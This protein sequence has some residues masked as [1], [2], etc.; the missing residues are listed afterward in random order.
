MMKTAIKIL[1][2]ILCTASMTTMAFGVQKSRTV[3]LTVLNTGLYLKIPKDWKQRKVKDG[4][5]VFIPEGKTQAQVFLYSVDFRASSERWQVAQTNLALDMRRNLVAQSTLDIG[6]IPLLITETT[7][8][9]K[10]VPMDAMTGLYYAAERH[11]LMFR[12]ESPDSVYS[13]AKADWQGVFQSLQTTDG[14]VLVAEDP[15]RPLTQEEAAAKPKA[16]ESTFELNAEKA[17]NKLKSKQKITLT[18][19]DRTVTLY[20]EKGW[21]ATQ[22]KSGW[23]WKL[24]K[25]PITLTMTISSTLDSPDPTTALLTTAGTQLSKFSAVTNRNE[26]VSTNKSG[27][28]YDLLDRIGTSAE[29]SKETIQDVEGFVSKGEFYLMFQVN[30]HKMLTKPEVNLIKNL[31]ESMDLTWDGQS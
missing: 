14:S 13:Q 2:L 3:N 15:N 27:A 30:S 10:K 12:L 7:Y 28:A 17:K 8:V 4:I 16:V 1:T 11:K 21:I 31:F 9:D 29:N 23:D 5:E 22:T 24:P 6:N 19:A 26:W 25:S 18:S 20:Y